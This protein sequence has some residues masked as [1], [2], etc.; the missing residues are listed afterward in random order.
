[1][2]RLD[3]IYYCDPEKPEMF[4]KRIGNVNR[5]EEICFPHDANPVAIE[6]VHE[7]EYLDAELK[8]G[9]FRKK[10]IYTI[11]EERDSNEVFSSSYKYK[12]V[13]PYAFHRNCKDHTMIV[14]KTPS[15]NKFLRPKTDDIK[16][17]PTTDTLKEGFLFYL[18]TYFEQKESEYERIAPAK[19]YKKM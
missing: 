9:F 16:A 7:V 14:Y 17:F 15:G 8:T 18:K 2:E 4:S 12:V 1:M 13:D 6:M 3:I 10:V 5:L 11:G 19:V